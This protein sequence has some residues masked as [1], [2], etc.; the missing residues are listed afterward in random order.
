MYPIAPIGVLSGTLAVTGFP[1][2]LFLVIATVMILSG[3]F[4]LRAGSIAR[5]RSST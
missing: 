2:A 1:V 3:L 5:R 4:F